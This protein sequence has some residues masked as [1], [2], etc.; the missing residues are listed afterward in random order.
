MMCIAWG[1]VKGINAINTTANFLH[2]K[3]LSLSRTKRQSL[4]LQGKEKTVSV[5]FSLI[6][7]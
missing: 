3:S 7:V 5:W 1:I 4:Y 6:H 2:A